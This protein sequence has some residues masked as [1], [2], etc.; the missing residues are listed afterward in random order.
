MR[1]KAEVDDSDELRQIAHLSNQ[2][3]ESAFADDLNNRVQAS[4]A[5]IDDV[6][7]VSVES[8]LDASLNWSGV[9]AITADS[10]CGPSFNSIDQLI[11]DLNSTNED[12]GNLSD[13]FTDDE[14][15]EDDDVIYLGTF[16]SPN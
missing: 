1:S 14:A 7:N 5:R 8:S 10:G 2:L 3:Y 13:F 6:Q 9:S 16:Q 15:N 11:D 4:P 12:A